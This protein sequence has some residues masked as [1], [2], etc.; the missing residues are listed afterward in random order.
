[1][2]ISKL[3]EGSR[4]DYDRSYA[5]HDTKRCSV[6]AGMIMTLERAERQGIV[7]FEQLI[8]LAKQG[9]NKEHVA[10]LE[11]YLEMF[12]EGTII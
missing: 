6:L 5:N 1:M 11:R 7:E 4:S 12:E 3:L 10:F 2:K 9:G 8:D